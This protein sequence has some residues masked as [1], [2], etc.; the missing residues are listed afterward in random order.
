MRKKKKSSETKRQALERYKRAALSM[1]AA[2]SVFFLSRFSPETFDTVKREYGG[3]RKKG[4]PEIRDFP[5]EIAAAETV[6]EDMRVREADA[7]TA[8]SAA[9]AAVER[10]RA[11]LDTLRALQEQYNE[12]GTTLAGIAGQT[13][14]A[15]S[16]RDTATAELSRL[17]QRAAER[18]ILVP[19]AQEV[20]ALAFEVSLLEEQRERAERLRSL[21]KPNEPHGSGLESVASRIGGLVNERPVDGLGCDGWYWSGVRPHLPRTRHQTSATGGD[22]SQSSRG[23]RSGGG[24]ATCPDRS[25][26][27]EGKSARYATG[28]GSCMRAG[29]KAGGSARPR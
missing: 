27:R 19:K 23:A 5:V 24:T 29:S 1:L 11:A 20:G 2:A 4:I 21:Q 13:A 3:R 15:A 8:S 16:R 28:S 7:A 26:S 17:D 18:A 6:L 10:T 22:K 12:L 25:Y 9:E 14:T